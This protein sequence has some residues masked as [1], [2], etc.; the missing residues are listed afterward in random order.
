MPFYLHDG[1]ARTLE[2]AILWHDG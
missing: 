2:K 1:K